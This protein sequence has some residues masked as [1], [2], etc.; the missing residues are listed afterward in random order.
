MLLAFN[1]K[2]NTN[3]IVK[4]IELLDKEYQPQNL[5]IC[6]DFDHV[7]DPVSPS[8][9]IA[10]SN[11]DNPRENLFYI[12]KPS[13]AIMNQYHSGLL[14]PGKY[15]SLIPCKSLAIEDSKN[16]NNNLYVEAY[17]V[18]AQEETVHLVK[19]V[20]SVYDALG[21]AYTC[22]IC[23]DEAHC[24]VFTVNGITVSKVVAKAV[25]E[26]TYVTTAT[27]LADPIFSYAVS[28]SN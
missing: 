26:D 17:I 10:R 25:N 19:T 3:A 24:V 5:P 4:A 20:K 2:I 23:E 22:A 27:V 21:V 11:I 14:L 6:V 15:Y 18:S 28:L 8:R 12:T 13:Q 7:F 16:Y 9:C 1:G